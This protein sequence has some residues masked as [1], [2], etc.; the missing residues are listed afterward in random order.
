MDL[1]PYQV[2]LISSVHKSWENWDRVIAVAPTGSGKA[3]MMA[4]IARDR[5]EHGPVLIL[6]HRQELIDQAIDKMEK[7][8][9]VFA[10]KEMSEN[11]ATGDERMVVASMQTLIRRDVFGPGHFK[12]VIVDECHHLVSESYLNLMGRYADAKVL[13]VTATPDR[14]D[15]KELGSYFQSVAYEIGLLDLIAQGYLSKIVVNRIP[16]RVD[17]SSVNKRAG[18]Y[19]S[20][21]LD[22]AISPWLTKI[23]AHIPRDRKVLVFLPLIATSKLFTDL[24]KAVGF[25]AEHIDGDSRDRSDI[26]ARFAAKKVGILSNS[27]LL[28][29]GYDCPSIDCVLVLRPTMSR[30][31]YSQMIGRGTRIYPGK[32]NL[33]VLDPLW[34]TGKHSLVKPTSL[35]TDS[36]E[37]AKIAEEMLDQGEMLDVE[38]VVDSAKEQREQSLINKLK[39]QADKAVGKKLNAIDPLEFAVSLHDARLAEYE[40]VMEWERLPPS[41]K[42]VQMIERFGLAGDKVTCKGHASAIINRIMDRQKLKLAS[43]KQLKWLI[44]LGH[45]KPYTESF[46]G[47]SEFLDKQFGGNKQ[48]K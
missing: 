39:E 3:V 32:E 27:M 30:P 45:P 9:G 21:D 7:A 34:L 46:A 25:D 5:M 12:T 16:V 1:R 15:K 23:L 18:E 35:V 6:A 22:S 44:K 31:L 28:I 8:T 11:R 19:A 24:A 29:E 38:R 40:P 41:P 10:T 42:Q 47:A 2:N 4:C 43:P 20:E 26:L 13:G 33:L 48:T 36:P 14:S 37:I 17:I